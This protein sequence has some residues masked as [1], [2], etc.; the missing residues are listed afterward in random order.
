MGRLTRSIVAA[1]GG[2]ARRLGGMKVGVLIPLSDGDG[3]AGAPS[4]AEAVAFARAAEDGG[5]DSAWLADH[6][7]YRDPAGA[8][9]GL[10]EAWTWLA[11]VA[12]A[13]SRIELGHLVAC[14]SF[15]PPALTAKLAATLDVIA[16]G[17]FILGLGCGWHEPEY[18]ALG[19]PFDHRVGRFEEALGVIKRLLAGETVTFHGR[20]YDLDEA[21]IAPAPARTIP[22]LI[23]ARRDRMLRI[24]AREAALWNTAWYAAPD[25]RLRDELAAFD[26]AM[27]VEGR[28]AGAVTRTVGVDV[29]DPDQPVAEP[30][31]RAFAGSVDD[32]ARLLEAYQKLG[33]GH[34]MV[35]LEPRTVRSVERLAEAVRVLRAA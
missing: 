6:L 7:F 25:E 21:V 22:L 5:L 9:S 24:A 3:S 2:S 16:K 23:A 18:R 20:F 1:G 17:R 13:T 29:R 30:D 10:H 4:F 26:R 28:P 11:G 12:A 8:V 27:E 14:T 32:L 15:R 31:D 34:L 35:G 19:V 33:I